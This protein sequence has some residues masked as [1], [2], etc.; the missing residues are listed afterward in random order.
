MMV[1]L[2]HKSL[3]KFW[4]DKMHLTFEEVTQLKVGDEVFEYDHGA[5]FRVKVL[6][7]PK[8]STGSEGRRTVSFLASTPLNECELLLTEGL[9]LNGPRFYRKPECTNIRQGKN[10]E[11]EYVF[12][13]W[14]EKINVRTY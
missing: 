12:E 2:H 11:V 1:N 7:D 10:G 13:I 14:G 6:T 4:V 8:I 3:E 5:I 9:E